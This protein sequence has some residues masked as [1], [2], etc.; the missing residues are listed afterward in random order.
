[1]SLL[2]VLSVIFSLIE[3]KLVT[4]LVALKLVIQSLWSKSSSSL[5]DHYKIPDGFE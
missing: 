1:M 5:Q 4:V 3:S 2:P